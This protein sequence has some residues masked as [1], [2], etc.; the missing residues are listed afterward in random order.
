M[1][2]FLAR[3]PPVTAD[4]PA[5]RLLALRRIAEA[6]SD[7]SSAWLSTAVTAYLDLVEATL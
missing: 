3:T 7:P 5:A 6:L 1:I 2:R 4:D